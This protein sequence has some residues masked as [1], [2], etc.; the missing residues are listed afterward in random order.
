MDDV[1]MR[2]GMIRVTRQDGLDQLS[3]PLLL[4]EAF[5]RGIRRGELTQRAE[6]RCIGIIRKLLVYLA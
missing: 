5:V 2:A 6:Q 1:M 3:R 4:R